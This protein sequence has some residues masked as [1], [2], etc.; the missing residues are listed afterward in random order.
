M[1]VRRLGGTRVH[2]VVVTHR[3]SSTA[4]LPAER[5]PAAARDRLRVDDARRQA[6]ITAALAPIPRVE[7]PHRT[8]FLLKGPIAAATTLVHPGPVASWHPPDLWWPDDRSWFV[9]TDVDLWS[10]YVGGDRAFLDAITAAVP[11]P[12][13]DV[14]HDTALVIED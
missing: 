1:L 8:Y 14:D 2:L 7:R 4:R 9:A 12:T 5:E 10:F 11:T 13:E 3:R 6:E